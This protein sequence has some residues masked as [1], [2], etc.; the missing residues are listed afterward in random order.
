M[1]PHLKMWLFQL[2]KDGS[3]PLVLGNTHML[4]HV[5]THTHAHTHTSCLNTCPSFFRN[6]VGDTSLT[7]S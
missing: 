6:L 1:L 5:H 2:L 4:A 3:Y 7:L